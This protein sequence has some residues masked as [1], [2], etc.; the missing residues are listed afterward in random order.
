MPKLKIELQPFHHPE[1]PLYI[2]L[3]LDKSKVNIEAEYF[4]GYLK[5]KDVTLQTMEC[6]KGVTLE[7]I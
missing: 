2:D 7:L 6:V 1:P 5:F 4:E 3:F